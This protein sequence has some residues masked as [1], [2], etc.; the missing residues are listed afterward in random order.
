MKLSIITVNYNN[1]EGLQKTIE[2]VLGQSVV[3]D[4]EY[5]IVDG[6][7]SDGGVDVLKQY[8]DRCT[9]VISEPDSGIYEAMNKGVRLSGG[10]YL[11][12]L[13]SGD[14]LYS[15]GTISEVLPEL[16]GADIIVGRIMK[17]PEMSL[18]KTGTQLSLF[19][20]IDNSL[21]HQGTFIR[22]TLLEQTPYDEKYK[23][24]SDWKFFVQAI[25]SGSHSYKYIDHIISNYDCNGLSSRN[26]DAS[27]EERN[28]ALSEMFPPRVLLDYRKFINGGGY[29]DTT[30][31]RFFVKLRNYR[32]GKI[33]Y[34]LD[35]LVLKIASI[36]MPG[37]RFVKFFPNRLPEK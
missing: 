2:S 30:Y 10:E 16:N 21:P 24:V 15:A 26:R 9:H 4:F 31:D 18:S 22:R 12:F 34:S 28:V 36:F 32:Y 37:A 17:V 3:D 7:S 6:A 35:V 11:L 29:E 23:I 5:I 20:F 14:T 25:I 1:K 13:N 8:E 27:M 19:Y 33:L